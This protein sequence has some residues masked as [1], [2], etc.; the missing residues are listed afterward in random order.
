MPPVKLRCRHPAYLNPGSQHRFIMLPLVVDGT[1]LPDN[2]S[3]LT[4]QPA[5]PFPVGQDSVEWF[6]HF[7]VD[8]PLRDDGCHRP[9]TW[10]SFGCHYPR[11]RL[12]PKFLYALRVSPNFSCWFLDSHAKDFVDEDA[13]AER[14][15]FPRLFTVGNDPIPSIL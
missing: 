1:P 12:G 15:S 5:N 4:F 6:R 3:L 7:L 11:P 8:M 2:F 10:V 13:R 14:L 9:A